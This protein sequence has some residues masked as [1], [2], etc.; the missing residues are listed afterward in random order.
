MAGFV[1]PNPCDLL[2]VFRSGIAVV[3]GADVCSVGAVVDDMS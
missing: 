1:A 2:D 3:A